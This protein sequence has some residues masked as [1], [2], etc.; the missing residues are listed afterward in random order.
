MSEQH[1]TR[2]IDLGVTDYQTAWDFQQQTLDEI[3]FARKNGTELKPNVLIFCE[4]PH[5]YTLG[6]SGAE[7]NLLINDDFLRKIEATYVKTNRGGD[8]TYHGPGQIVAYPIFDLSTMKIGIKDYVQNIEEAVIGCLSNYDIKSERLTG[9]TGVWLDT[10]IKSRTRKICA[11]G[12]RVS[13]FVTMH[14][15][16]F[17]VNTDLRYFDYI[18]PCGF[19]D[20]GVTSLQKECKKEMSFSEVKSKLFDEF[21]SVFNLKIVD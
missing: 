18:N 1:K 9:A 15:L 7:N 16:A 3:V 2:F 20:K 4:H 11:I 12:V 8:I 5:V 21:V 19:T 6:K 10:E 17:N 14:G 13:N